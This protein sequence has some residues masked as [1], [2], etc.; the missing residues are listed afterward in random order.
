M[1]RKFTYT[2]RPCSICGQRITAN[3]FAMIA[4][5]RKHVREGVINE[6]SID[7]RP[8]FAKPSEGLAG[9]KDQSRAGNYF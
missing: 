5:L 4:H 6:R 2:K 3:G 9:F 8:A 7:G 1:D